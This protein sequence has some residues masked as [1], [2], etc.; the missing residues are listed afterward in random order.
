FQQDNGKKFDIED[1]TIANHD[2][3]ALWS[4]GIMY[5]VSNWEGQ[6]NVKQIPTSLT[7]ENNTEGICYD[8]VTGNLLIACKN[9]SDINDAK[10]STRAIYAYD[11]KKDK[12]I[13]EPFMTIERKNFKSEEND[14]IEFFP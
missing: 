2:V 9:E 1:V 8:P 13:E 12:L 11:L 5:K 3:Y 10:K 6:P 14:K 7:K 4:H